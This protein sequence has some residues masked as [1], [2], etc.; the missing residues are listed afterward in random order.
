MDKEILKEIGFGLIYA[1]IP[2][3]SGSKGVKNKNIRGINGYPLIAYSIAAAKLC[4]K[5]SRIIVSTDSEYY[6]DI[7]KYYGAEV[8]FLRPEEF[9]TDS[10]PDIEFVEHAISWFARNEGIVPEYFVHLRPTYPLRKTETVSEAIV[11]MLENPKAT[12]LRSAH[13]ADFAP[14]KW[15]IKGRDGYFRCL[16][17]GMTPDEANQARQGFPTV[18]IPDGYVDVL[19][20]SFIV[21]NDLLHGEKVSAFEVPS[22][23]DVDTPHEMHEIERYMSAHD[24]ELYRYLREN[25]KTMEDAGL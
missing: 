17:D 14:Y 25:Y 24:H 21:E 4:P 11:K 18:Y 15:F 23:T 9:A 12:S 8:P 5:I 16:F 2:A 19:R 22:G 3:R 6:A 1:L 10:S 7:A 20:T 13:P